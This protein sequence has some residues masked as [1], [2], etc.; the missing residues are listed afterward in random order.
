[1]GTSPPSD[2]CASIQ[3]V[4]QSYL[5]AVIHSLEVLV[6]QYQDDDTLSQTVPPYLLP[7]LWFLSVLASEILAHY[8][9]ILNDHLPETR[10][11]VMVT[12]I[13]VL[14]HLG[15]ANDLL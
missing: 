1:M 5:K 14:D 10:V 6:T 8:L 3:V 11:P 7:S 4:A 9:W 2:Q 15:I 13:V 12:Q